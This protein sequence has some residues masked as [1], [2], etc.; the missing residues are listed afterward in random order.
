M[1]RP[2][3]QKTLPGVPVSDLTAKELKLT[4]AYLQGPLSAHLREA[5]EMALR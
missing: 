2:T 4:L 1:S 3:C 5:P